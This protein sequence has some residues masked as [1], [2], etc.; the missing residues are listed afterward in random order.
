MT[1]PADLPPVR[2]ATAQDVPAL[3]ALVESAYRIYLP[4]M[5]KRP[6][7]MLADYAALVSAGQVHCQDCQGRPAGLLVMMPRPE[8]DP[9]HLH[10]ENVAVEPSF[11]GRGIG[12]RL[13]GYASEAAET[14]GFARLCLYT[15]ALMHENLAF[16]RRLGFDVEDRRREAGYDRVYLTKELT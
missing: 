12:R 4:R 11:Q 13:L 2:R 8:G 3:L 7:P 10:I 15:N 1:E 5:D 6:A 9:D 16:Y 14:G